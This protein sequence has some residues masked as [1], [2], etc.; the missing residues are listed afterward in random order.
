[1]ETAVQIFAIIN[2]GTVGLSHVLAPRA[3]A[4][5]F[6]LLREKGHAGVFVVAFMSLWFGSI[7]AAFHNAWS[8]I[9]AVLTVLGWAQVV[10]ALIYFC[11]PAYGLRALATV[12]VE[13]AR[14][15]VYAG[16]GL[17]ALASLLAYHLWASFRAI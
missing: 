1:M 13:R 11:Y 16:I 3:W 10:K 8:G 7:I 6:I 17:L 15:F 5:F 12:S 2:L 9:P 4:E 14:V